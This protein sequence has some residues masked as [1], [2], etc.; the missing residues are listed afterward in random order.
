LVDGVEES[1]EFVEQTL[2]EFLYQL[3][4]LGKFRARTE[5]L[6]Y[7]TELTFY[8]VRNKLRAIE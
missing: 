7:A 1:W 4:R 3:E 8:A 2:L 6:E 5:P